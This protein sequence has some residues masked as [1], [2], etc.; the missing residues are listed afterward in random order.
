MAMAWSSVRKSHGYAVWPASEGASLRSSAMA[1]NASED[2]TWN[3]YVRMMCVSLEIRGACM[4]A[5]IRDE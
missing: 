5:M 2:G 1:R 3:V 4:C